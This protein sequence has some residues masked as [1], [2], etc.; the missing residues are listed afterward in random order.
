MRGSVVDQAVEAYTM[1]VEQALAVWS[2]AESAARQLRDQ[3]ATSAAQ[4]YH[5]VL[6][7]LHARASS[8]FQDY[9]NALANVG[10]G[11]GSSPRSNQSGNWDWLDYAANFAA[12]WGDTLSFNLTNVVRNA[13][14][15]NDGIDHH[16][17]TYSVGQWTGVA[18]MTAIGAVAGVHAAGTRGAGREFSHWIPARWGGPRTI[19]NG[20]YVSAR[21]HALSDPWRYRFMSKAWK[22]ENPLPSHA[23]QQVVRI[24]NVYKG[25]AV[26]LGS[27]L[28]SLA[29][30]REMME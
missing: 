28:G 22:A 11:E 20:N 10:C 26:G 24:P 14:S 19:F 4:A 2:Q 8:A 5:S 18:H 30:N 21:T 3:R 6:D 17:T 25:I 12:G 16:S 7:R 23:W 29:L 1:A 27:G 9:L 13:V 15:I